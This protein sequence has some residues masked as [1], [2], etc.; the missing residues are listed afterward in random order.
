MSSGVTSIWNTIS[1]DRTSGRSSLSS[2]FDQAWQT[3]VATGSNGNGGGMSSWG[4]SSSSS[5]GS[6]SGTSTS[7]WGSGDK[8]KSYWGGW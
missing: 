5:S 6:S 3:H 4:A 1:N 2:T 7:S 8:M